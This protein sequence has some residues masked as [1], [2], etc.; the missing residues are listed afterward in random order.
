[1]FHTPRASRSSIH[2]DS[3]CMNEVRI[4]AMIV[5]KRRILTSEDPHIRRSSHQRILVDPHRGSSLSVHNSFT[6]ALNDVIVLYNIHFSNTYSFHGCPLNQ[7]SG[8]SVYK[9]FHQFC[10]EILPTRTVKGLLNYTVFVTSSEAQ[11]SIHSAIARPRPPAHKIQEIKLIM[12]KR[13]A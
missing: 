4:L 8:P 11:T 7:Y 10:M 12:L 5:T 3:T 6:S 2:N 9:N 1:M 13:Y